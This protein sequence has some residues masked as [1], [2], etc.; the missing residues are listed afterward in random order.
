MANGAKR[1]PKC[2]RY[3][4]DDWTQCEGECPMSP[5]PHF[6]AL[7]AHAFFGEFEGDQATAREEAPGRDQA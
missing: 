1:C 4:G 2:K 6:S 3:S 7:C 5:S